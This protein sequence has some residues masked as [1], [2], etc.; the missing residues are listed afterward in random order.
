MPV[1]SLRSIILHA[2]L[3]FT[4][5]LPTTPVGRP[6]SRKLNNRP[7]LLFG[8]LPMHILLVVVLVHVRVGPRCRGDLWG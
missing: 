7:P 2:V 8:S 5:S 6:L 4:A 1:H 3:L